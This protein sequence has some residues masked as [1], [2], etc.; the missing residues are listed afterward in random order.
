MGQESKRSQYG[1]SDLGSLM[2]LQ[3]DNGE[4]QDHT[5]DFLPNMF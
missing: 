4:D 2:R 1:P 3:R 5:E